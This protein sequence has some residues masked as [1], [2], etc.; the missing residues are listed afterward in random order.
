MIGNM[1]KRK[2]ISYKGVPVNIFGL[3]SSKYTKTQNKILARPY[4]RSFVSDFIKYAPK[5]LLVIYDIPETRK[6]DRDWFR[7]QLKNFDFVMIQRSV[8]VGPSPLPVDFLNYLKT[9][10]L[11]DKFKTFKLAKAYK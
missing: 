10:G 4:L 3:P 9:I 11:K 7:R 6:K 2:K 8:W 1:V 5:N